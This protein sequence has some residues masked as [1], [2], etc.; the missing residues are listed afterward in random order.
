MKSEEN[1]Y[2][3]GYKLALQNALDL[4]AVSQLACKRRNYGVA[5]SLNILSAEE[6]IKSMFILLRHIFPNLEI[7]DYDKV[8]KYHNF[9]HKAIEEFAKAYDDLMKKLYDSTKS[10]IM[11]IADKL[12]PQQKKSIPVNI[13]ELQKA[14]RFIERYNSSKTSIKDLISWIANANN[15][16]NNGLYVG[17]IG[18]KWSSPDDFRKEK[19][20][21]E[22]DYTSRVIEMARQLQLMYNQVMNGF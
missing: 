6:G 7:E 19:Y 9:K 18:K 22:K 21:K 14:W 10:E 13:D 5:C 4:Q 2:L 16:K 20:L 3:I 11:K 17:E 15:D 12:S 8:F 1:H